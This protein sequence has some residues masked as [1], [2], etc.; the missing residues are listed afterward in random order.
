MELLDVGDF[1]E[2]VK[3]RFSDVL[4]PVTTITK[5]GLLGKG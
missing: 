5:Q 3:N 2:Y 1:L 4:L